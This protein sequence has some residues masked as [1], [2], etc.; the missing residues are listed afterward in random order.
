MPFLSLGD[1]INTRTVRHRGNSP[2][3]GNFV[4]ED[5]ESEGQMY[6]RLVFLSSKNTVQSEARLVRGI[7]LVIYS[8][9][10]V[11]TLVQCI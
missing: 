5:V 3:S 10:C 7:G 1:D 2:F 11:C 8:C 6:R 9:L 4:V